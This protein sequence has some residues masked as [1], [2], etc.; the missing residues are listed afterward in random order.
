MAD[1]MAA[2]QD[3]L[4][5]GGLDLAA[6][7]EN[8][9]AGFD[10]DDEVMGGLDGLSGIMDGC[11]R[12]RRD[13]H[14]SDEMDAAMAD[15][16]AAA[17]DALAGGG[18]DLAALMENAMAGFDGDDEVMGGLD[19]LSGIADGCRRRVRQR[20]DAHVSGSGEMDFEKMMED[21]MA[22]AQDALAGGGLDL[23]SLMGGLGDLMGGLAD[24]SGL[25]GLGTNINLDLAT[26]MDD[27]GLGGMADGCRRQRRFAHEGAASGLG[28]LMGGT[29]NS[30]EDALAAMQDAMAGGDAFDSTDWEVDGLDALSFENNFVNNLP[31][32][33]ISCDCLNFAIQAAENGVLAAG[34][35]QADVIGAKAQAAGAAAT[36]ATVAVVIAV[37]AAIVF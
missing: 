17:Q 7:M 15:A 8:A 19:G 3:A 10:G 31:S 9:M 13:A 35:T 32:A 37:V 23:D 29:G 5:G 1:A 2:A 20:R 12:Q 11:R 33:G 24:G 22:A 25:G 30:V 21:A 36:T 34:G 14:V 18:L 6:L 4:A 27:L 16:M 28:A 26:S